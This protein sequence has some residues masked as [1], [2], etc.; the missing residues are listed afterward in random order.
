[1]R[2]SELPVPA[3]RAR[4][5]LRAAMLSA[6]LL[7]A[8]RTVER[9]AVPARPDAVRIR[10]DIAYLADDRLEGRA[11][12]TAGN[13]TAASWLARRHAALKLVPIV[14]DT[15]LRNCPRPAPRRCTTYLQR[16]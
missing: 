13:D 14:V 2:T 12:G 15:T 7:A 1:M 11:T 16:F 8:C 4:A 10:S 6:A 9:G 3:P 5:A